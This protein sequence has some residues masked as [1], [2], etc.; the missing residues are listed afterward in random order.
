MDDFLISVARALLE[1]LLS[2]ITKQIQTIEEQAMQPIR[3]VLGLVVGGIWKGE[4][5]NAFVE[6]VSSIVIPGVARVT[7]HITKTHHNLS[8][9][10]DIVERA[11]SDVNNLVRSNLTDKF[12]FY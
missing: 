2:Q 3:M 11:D 5:A 4:G 10:R 9:A 1:S 7:E 6:E 12:K 8:N